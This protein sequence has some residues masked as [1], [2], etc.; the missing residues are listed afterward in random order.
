[1]KGAGEKSIETNGGISTAIP[2]NVESG[3][4]FN[5]AQQLS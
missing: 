4:C 2:G 3:S 1:M 5:S